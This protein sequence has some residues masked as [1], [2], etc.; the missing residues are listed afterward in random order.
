M[1]V[2]KYIMP[3]DYTGELVSNRVIGEVHEPVGSAHRLVFPYGGMFYTNNLKV[4]D[5]ANKPLM[6][7][8]DYECL[9]A[10]QDIT[11]CTP[12][13]EVCGAIVLKPH[14]K[15]AT[16]SVNTNYVGGPHAN[17]TKAIQD[18][19]IAAD[20][21]NRNGDFRELLGKPDY[22]TAGPHVE[23]I[24]NVYGFEYVLTALNRL[25]DT[26][27][28]SKAAESE[29]VS[30]L[31]D[32]LITNINLMLEDHASKPNAH[33]TKPSDIGTYTSDQIDKIAHD[34][35]NA[36]ELVR[37]T[38]DEVAGEQGGVSGIV[39]TMDSKL[40]RFNRR[41]TTIDNVAK[42]AI[43]RLAAMEAAPSE[44]ADGV[45]K[46][47]LVKQ[48]LEVLGS[49]TSPTGV[50][51]NLTVNN[52]LAANFI[53]AASVTVSGALAANHIT[54][55]GI[56]LNGDMT[57]DEIYARIVS[58]SEK[59]LTAYLEATNLKVANQLTVAGSESIAY[60]STVGRNQ[61]VAGTST[62]G[63]QTVTNQQTVGNQTVNGSSTVR[64]NMRVDTDLSTGG[65]ASIGR[66]LY[67]GG[68]TNSND[69]YIRSDKR[70]KIKIKPLTRCLQRV[71]KLI[72]VEYDKYHS[73][74]DRRVMHEYGMIAD[75]VLGVSEHLVGTE[76]DLL[77]IRLYGIVALLTGAVKELNGNVEKQNRLLA[78]TI[79]HVKGHGGDIESIKKLLG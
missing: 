70:L 20:L 12:G 29:Q 69:V 51:D 35:S 9:Y 66:D 36:I 68:N 4:F 62:V 26:I 34:L 17:Y 23:D 58:A 45:Y 18:A 1:S 3:L 38:V 19:L 7:E 42:N 5:S 63:N 78:K 48:I 28:K 71:L 30:N 37:Q 24:G 6:R 75:Q 15:T 49:I 60:D 55:N 54:C 61:S 41:I 43:R 22:F 57:A 59:L 52:M 67:V 11:M 31:L 33:N 53:N 13:L 47:L 72:P 27:A 64:G 65:G 8:D 56:T 39:E 16:V 14:V 10:D 21:D 40:R 32:D 76:D 25:T 73:L 77:A 50:F 44:N 2:K 74:T 79:K 46:N